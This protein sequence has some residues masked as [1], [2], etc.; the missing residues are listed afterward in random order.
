MDKQSNTGSIR[1]ANDRLIE[2]DFQSGLHRQQFALTHRSDRREHLRHREESAQYH[3]T[4]SD[5]LAFHSAGHTLTRQH[6]QETHRTHLRSL[7]QDN[8][9][10]NLQHLAFHFTVDTFSERHH[11]ALAGKE[12]HIAQLAGRLDR[13]VKRH[14]DARAHRHLQTLR[15]DS[16]SRESDRSGREEREPV[17]LLRGC[18]G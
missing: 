12:P 13:L 18:G 11:I 16:S 2:G 4:H 17:E 6:G 7:L 3:V 1:R 14:V 15:V 10:H 8:V 9:H 5:I